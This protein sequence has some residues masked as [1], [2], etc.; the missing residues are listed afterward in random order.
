MIME[1]H[2]IIT[3]VSM[4]SI[5]DRYIIVVDIQTIIVRLLFVSTT[6]ISVLFF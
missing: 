1:N 2:K 4:G 3:E 5:I 6:I